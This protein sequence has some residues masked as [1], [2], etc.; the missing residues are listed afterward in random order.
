MG[1]KSNR[2]DFLKWMGI[3]G[4]LMASG[5]LSLAES[6]EALS[7]SGSSGTASSTGM[8][9]CGFQAPALEK[10]RVGVV[11]LGMRGSGAVNRLGYVGNFNAFVG[12]MSHIQL[13]GSVSNSGNVVFIHERASCSAHFQAVEF[14]FFRSYRTPGSSEHL[15]GSFDQGVI[16][17]CCPGIGYTLCHH[18][19]S[20][21]EFLIFLF[22]IHFNRNRT[23]VFRNHGG[24]LFN[25]KHEV[26]VA[27]LL[28]DFSGD[29]D[30]GAAT[31]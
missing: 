1:E 28:A 16:R 6:A 17:V 26:L 15:A 13:P 30:I 31:P 21:I 14:P 24:V 7:S 4:G 3:G 10:V 12:C 23:E 20:G 29:L 18:G 5:N 11:G 25:M 22:D 8:N 2:R 9:M 27:L 19:F